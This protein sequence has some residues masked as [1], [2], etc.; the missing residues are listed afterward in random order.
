[1]PQAFDKCQRAGGEIRTIT[2]PNKQWNVA[3]GE[4]V[5]I[6][7]VPGKDKWVRGYTKKKGSEQGEGQK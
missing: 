7:K 5:R 1:M 4:Y 6:C 3:Q 2:G